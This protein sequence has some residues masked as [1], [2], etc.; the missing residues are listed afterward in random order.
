MIGYQLQNSSELKVRFT[1]MNT[2]T[3]ALPFG[4]GWHPYV[5]LQQ[6]IDELE[7][8]MPRVRRVL[9]DERMLPVNKKQDYNDFSSLR[10]IANTHL[11]DCFEIQESSG[12]ARVCLWSEKQQM[13]L[14]VWQEIGEHGCRFLQIC[15]ALDRLSIAIEPMSCSID[16]FNSNDGLRV[17]RPGES[18]STCFGIKLVTTKKYLNKLPVFDHFRS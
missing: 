13:G 1:V 2:G 7:L 8:Q 4:I 14:E 17:L 9:V 6:P 15:T 5:Q 16:A 18:F 10:R 12:T 11:D 3:T